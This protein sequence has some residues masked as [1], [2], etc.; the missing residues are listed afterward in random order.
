MLTCGSFGPSKSVTSISLTSFH[1]WRNQGPGRKHHSGLLR[2][3]I[4]VF[5]VRLSIHVVFMFVYT[6]VHVCTHEEAEAQPHL[7]SQLV[8]AFF[9]FFFEIGVGRILAFTWSFQ[10]HLEL[11][12]EP[13]GPKCLPIP[14]IRI[15]RMCGQTLPLLFLCRLWDAKSGLSVSPTEPS[16]TYLLDFCCFASILWTRFFVCSIDVPM[17]CC[18]LFHSL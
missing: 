13:Q 16:S 14:I 2:I 10:S 4:C 17:C 1:R 3:C 18:L 8:F 12:S 9:F 6:S 15:L 7:S 11:F 5:S